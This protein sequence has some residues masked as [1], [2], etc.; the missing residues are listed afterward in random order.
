MHTDNASNSID[1][2]HTHTRRNDLFIFVHAILITLE[3]IHLTYVV[4]IYPIHKYMLTFH[5]CVQLQSLVYVGRCFV[6]KSVPELS[7]VFYRKY[8]IV[9]VCRSTSH[10]HHPSDYHWR[11]RTSPP[12]SKSI[13]QQDNAGRSPRFATSPHQL[14]VCKQRTVIYLRRASSTTSNS[15]PDTRVCGDTS[16]CVCGKLYGVLF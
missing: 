3:H 8:I 15:L 7:W 12:P 9:I 11:H 13:Q 1:Q 16:S 10:G 14:H 4:G 2:Q 5:L 6:I